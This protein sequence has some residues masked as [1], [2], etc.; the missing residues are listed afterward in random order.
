M[1]DVAYLLALIILRTELIAHN[2]TVVNNSDGD[3]VISFYLKAT[4]LLREITN[5]LE[6][7]QFTFV[8]DEDSLASVTYPLSIKVLN[9]YIDY[10]QPEYGENN[11]YEWEV[12]QYIDQV[13]IP[14]LVQYAILEEWNG[15]NKYG[16]TIKINNNRKWYKE[17]L[18]TSDGD[19]LYNALLAVKTIR[20][21]YRIVETAGSHINVITRSGSVRTTTSKDC[22]CK[23]F[24]VA[25]RRKIPCQHIVLT[26]VYEENR[27]LFIDESQG[28]YKII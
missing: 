17:L 21:G 26:K 14:D 25:N 2:I 16:L 1:Y 28:L 20:E 5:N 22:D 4:G 13:I 15:S 6:S 8:K 9:K 24:N 19:S 18:L 23:Q 12:E 7:E 27:K 3:E 11:E 10:K